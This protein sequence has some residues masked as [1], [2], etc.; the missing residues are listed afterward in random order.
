MVHTTQAG[1]NHCSSYFKLKMRERDSIVNFNHSGV[2]IERQLW[3][4]LL[5][6]NQT[7]NKL[8]GCKAS[9]LGW[10]IINNF[11]LTKLDFDT[12]SSQH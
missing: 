1:K 9:T 11:Y 10:Y 8:N 5:I 3:S 4:R 2:K 7:V 12:V 6:L